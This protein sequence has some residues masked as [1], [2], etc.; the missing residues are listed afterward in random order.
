MSTPYSALM[1]GS[2]TVLASNDRVSAPTGGSQIE[3]RTPAKKPARGW[4]ARAIQ[5][6]QPPADGNTF[7]SY[8]A[9]SACLE[10]DPAE[11]VRPWGCDPRVAHDEHERREDREGGRDRRDPLHQYPGE[12]DR[13]LP[14]FGPDRPLSRLKIL[15]CHRESP[16]RYPPEAGSRRRGAFG[17]GL[18]IRS[19][20]NIDLRLDLGKGPTLSGAQV[21]R[22]G[23]GRATKPASP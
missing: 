5:V 1:D 23:P 6:Y 18:T 22:A 12:P 8:A 10:E 14:Q 19:S 9:D 21:Y 2:S 15:D 11:Q 13:V 20:R 4:K 17:H 16:S 3:N 7:A